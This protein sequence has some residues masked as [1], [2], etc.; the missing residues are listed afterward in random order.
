MQFQKQVSIPRIH[1]TFRKDHNETII[2]GV[3]L[4]AGL[5]SI[6]QTN[7]TGDSTHPSSRNFTG[8][9]YPRIEADNRVTFRFNAAN[10]Q[11]V[12]VSIVN[13]P[14]DIVK[15]DDGAWTYR[16]KSR[17]LPDITTTG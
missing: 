5:S 6:A 7:S 1:K 11:K 14:F 17:R 13:V 10:A 8:V 4:L 2:I 16:P 3:A 15:G 12:Q 9:Q